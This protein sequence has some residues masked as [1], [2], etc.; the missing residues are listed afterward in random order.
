M[1][2]PILLAGP[3][4]RLMLHAESGDIPLKVARCFPWAKPNQFLSLRDE[5]GEEKLLVR[6][7]A[8]LEPASRAVLEKELRDSGQTFE[9]TAIR[10]CRKEIELRCWDV[11][12][13]QG[14]RLFQTELDEWPTKIGEGRLLIEDLCGDLYTIDNPAALDPLS[15]R[16]L[17]PLLD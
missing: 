14:P 6:D 3:D 2:T 13:R 15:R 9:I 4:G 11:E 7:P 1:N 8:D 17:W 12:T 10:E 5:K 16:L